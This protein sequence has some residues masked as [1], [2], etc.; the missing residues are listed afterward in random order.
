[1]ARALLAAAMRR[2]AELGVERA[3][4]YPV[5]PPTSGARIPPAFA[6]TGTR[7]L[8]ESAGFALEPGSEAHGKQRVRKRLS[9]AG[10]RG[11]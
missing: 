4:G 10:R 8:F 11:G 3:E 5:K 2:M 1:M 7:S 6:Y 9:P